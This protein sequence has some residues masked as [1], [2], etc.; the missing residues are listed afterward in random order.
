M[1]SGT[2]R[3]EADAETLV[4]QFG[5]LRISV[6]GRQEVTVADSRTVTISSPLAQD[7]EVPLQADQAT[8]THLLAGA[9]SESTSSW[10]VVEGLAEA[11]SWT[12]AWEASILR[13]EEAE[14]FEAADLS[15]V[16]HL[17]RRLRRVGSA[18]TGR[19]RVGRALRA[20]LT[21]RQV[22]DG[23]LGIPLRTPPLPQTLSERVYVVL[24]AAPG[25][26]PGWTILHPLSTLLLCLVGSRAF[27]LRV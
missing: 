3:D 22:L 17:S 6:R 27:I 21:A 4:L 24:R 13:C 16:A 18:W 5:E 10:I 25:F 20:G 19:A 12:P 15:P 8:W 1:S 2:G 9:S 26:E 7:K 14:Q 11:F 23:S